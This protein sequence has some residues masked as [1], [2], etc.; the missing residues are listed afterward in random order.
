MSRGDDQDDAFCLVAAAVANGLHGPVD[1]QDHD[2]VEPGL[3]GHELP[4]AWR[5]VVGEYVRAGGYRGA[6]QPPG[7]GAL[8]Y[9][10]GRVAVN[11]P[12]LMR[13][14][15]GDHQDLACLGHEPD[16]GGHAGAIALEGGEAEVFALELRRCRPGLTAP[17]WLCAGAR[18]GAAGA[19]GGLRAYPEP[20]AAAAVAA[21]R[22]ALCCSSLSA[23]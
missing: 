8:G 9:R 1:R 21:A 7:R 6:A 13:I 15:V 12:D 17:R 23:R 2:L 20:A 19:H 14:G 22:S 10:D 16:R 18:G 11:P 4:G 5:L 3:A